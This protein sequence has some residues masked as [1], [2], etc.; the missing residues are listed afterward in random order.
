MV[1]QE[2]SR[3]FFQGLQPDLEARTWQHL[4]QKFIDHFPDDP[5]NISTIYKAV[6]YV[7]GAG[8]AASVLAPLQVP[9]LPTTIPSPPIDQ[10]SAKIEPLM[11][12][13]TSLGEM[14]KTAIQSQPAGAKPRS[15]GV[16]ATG[17]SAPGNSNCNFCGGTGHFIQECEV[18]MEFICISKC[19]CSADGKVVLPS[20]AMVPHGITGTWLHDHIDEYHWQNLGQMAAQMLF[21][22]VALVAAP[23]EVAAGQLWNRYPT[24]HMDQ[25]YS[26]D[27]VR[28]Y[29]LNQLHRPRPEV[30]ITTRP[31]C[32]GSH[33]SQVEDASSTDREV[34]P[35]VMEKDTPL[36]LEKATSPDNNRPSQEH[37]H[38]YASVPDAT[39]APA[40]IRA[41]V[42]Q[43]P[44]AQH[45]PAYNMATKIHNPQ[46]AKVMFEHTMETP[47]MVTQWELL[48]LASEV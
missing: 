36:Q 29:A 45:N 40:P 44:A 46:I 28:A 11:A 13:M 14:F 43:A 23:A 5:Y 4:Q 26:E 25:Y 33:V 1:M 24:W 17:I 48:S 19:K 27:A 12:V 20:G 2:Q 47:I 30:V 18:V 42:P 37:T 6:S 41:A 22:V 16:A 3:A 31:L 32:R 9:T 39:Y 38:L 15:T 7:L 34:A 35:H 8:P 10:T 21:E